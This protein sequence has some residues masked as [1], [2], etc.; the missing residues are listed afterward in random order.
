MKP[1]VSILIPAYNAERWIAYT[2][3]SAV[4][5]TWERK[6]IIVVDDGSTDGTANVARQFASKGVKV[7]STENQG[8][9]GAVNHAYKLCQGDYIQELDS[10]DLL[11]PD[12]IELQLATL[13]DGDSKRLLLSSPWG[14]FFFRPSRARFIENCLWHDLSPAEW[15]LGKLS[16]N[17]HMQNATWLVSRE[18]AESAGPWD[19]RLHYDQDGEYFARVLLKSEGTRFVRESRVFYRLSSSNRISY[20]GKSNEK[21]NSLLLSM[22]LQ[23]QYI[24]SI[25]DSERVR[26]ACLVYLQNWYQ[27]FYPDRPDIIE[28][29]Q[30][31]ATELGGHLE[32]PRLHWKYAWIKSLF[33]WSVTKWVERVFPEAKDSL[34]RRWDKTMFQFE[35]RNAPFVTPPIPS[36]N[37]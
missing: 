34:L 37:R 2:L 33:G 31:L 25:E 14:Y 8:L 35:T 12:K 17:V 3:Q 16:E 36:A 21:K 23:I 11:A 13:R 1:L 7:V 15:M 32:E 29:L 4:A 28:V 19:T 20:I 22:M 5:Q 27:N 10:D 30:S 18:L 26:N 6:E 24:R 9:C